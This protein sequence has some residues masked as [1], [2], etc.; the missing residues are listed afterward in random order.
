ME[1]MADYSGGDHQ[2]VEY[3]PSPQFG[4][5]HAS[6]TSLRFQLEAAQI[7]EEIEHSLRCETP[8]YNSRTDEI[9]MVRPKGVDPIINDF[10]INKVLVI[11]RSRL[12]QIFILSALTDDA[13]EAITIDVGETLADDLYYNWDYYQIKD[14]AAASLI[15][16]TVTDTVYATLCKARQARYLT[17]LGTTQSVSE[18][19]HQI[20]QGGRTGGGPSQEQSIMDRLLR[21]KR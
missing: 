21:R 10:G 1:P 6:E 2:Q 3:Y 18:N 13:I 9:E 15:T 8:K 14:D 7:I 12:N 16:E 19:I 11:L 20:A 17:F 4:Q 5:A